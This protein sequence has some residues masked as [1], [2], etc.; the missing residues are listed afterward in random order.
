[1]ILQ[2]I[3]ASLKKRD[4][5]TVVLEVLIVVVGIF[6]GLQV[7]DW[8]QRRQDRIDERMFLARLHDEVLLANDL[9]SSRRQRRLNLMADL[10]TATE[11]LFDRAG[12]DK[13]TDEECI[14]IGN[15]RFF[16]IVISNLPSLTELVSAG[17]LQIIQDSELRL[18][19]IE[20]QQRIEVLNELIPLLT[21]IRVNLPIEYPN[22]IGTSVYFDEE[23]NEFEQRYNCDLEGMRES[24]S[25]LSGISLGIEAYDVYLQDGLV[26]WSEQLDKI[27]R[28]LAKRLGIDSA[29]EL[30][31]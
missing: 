6:I 26:P 22:L 5:G 9:A 12:R 2:R 11:V 16:N 25:F 17:R 18:G 13:L 3:A 1:M 21:S 4:W 23:L 10:A 24:S 20:L 31:P 27:H 29:N 14:A 8:N 19:I 30:A 28:L 7:D 15:S